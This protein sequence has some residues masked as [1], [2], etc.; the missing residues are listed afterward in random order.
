M[1]LT[2]KVHE[3]IAAARLQEVETDRRIHEAFTR[4]SVGSASTDRIVAE[5]SALLGCTVT[6][7]PLE[8]LVIND[9]C[10]A[11]P[12][13]VQTVLERAGQDV[14]I[15]VLAHQSQLEMRCSMAASLFY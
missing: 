13:L 11:E 12:V 5:A 15:S 14:S 7:E 6:W 10:H 9:P 3:S 2:Q 1:E 4:L 8:Q